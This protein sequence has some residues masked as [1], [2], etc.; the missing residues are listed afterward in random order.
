MYNDLH[1]KIR[2]VGNG[3]RE[4]IKDDIVFEMELVK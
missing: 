4:S 1:E 3:D 2:H